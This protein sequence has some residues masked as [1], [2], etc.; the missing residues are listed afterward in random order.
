MNELKGKSIKRRIATTGTDILVLSEWLEKNK[1]LPP[2]VKY[3]VE[4]AL[5]DAQDN[6]YRMQLQL[7]RM[8]SGLNETGSN[9]ND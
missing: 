8:L 5:T 2:Q 7:S 9:Q 3:A 4:S 6:L 1:N